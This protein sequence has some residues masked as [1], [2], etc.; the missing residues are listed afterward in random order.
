MALGLLLVIGLEKIGLPHHLQDNVGASH[1]FAIRQGE[2]VR[3]AWT[4]LPVISALEHQMVAVD[5][6]TWG[7]RLTTKWS[8]TSDLPCV[9]VVFDAS[10]VLVNQRGAVILEVNYKVLTFVASHGKHVWVAVDLLDWCVQELVAFLAPRLQVELGLGGSWVDVVTLCLVEYHKVNTAS[11]LTAC[12]VAQRV[13]DCWAAVPLAGAVVLQFT[14]A[15]GESRDV[16][17]SKEGKVTFKVDVFLS[18]GV[19][20]RSIVIENETDA[21]AVTVS[22]FDVLWSVQDVLAV[23]DRASFGGDQVEGSGGV[24]CCCDCCKG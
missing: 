18:W 4:C 13:V 10:S 16:V 24:D 3:T 11:V 1:T 14:V 5:S 21:I 22:K 2:L 15:N 20:K 7:G 23:I 12:V 17:R 6:E 8:N 9:G 19:H